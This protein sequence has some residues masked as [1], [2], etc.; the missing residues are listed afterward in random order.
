LKVLSQEQFQ[1]RMGEL[2]AK[3]PVISN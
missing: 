3:Y 2:I 1:A